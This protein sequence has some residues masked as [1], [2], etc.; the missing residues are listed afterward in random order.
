MTFN[1]VQ[2]AEQSRLRAERLL[3]SAQDSYRTRLDQ[4]KLLIGM[5]VDEPLEV[6]PVDVQVTLPRVAV[7]E[8]TE[9]ASRFR[10]DLQ[11]A[12]DRVEDAQRFVQVA[13]NGLLPDLNFT[14]EARWRNLDSTPARDI[15]GRATT[16]SAGIELDLPIDR[17]D[18]RNVYRRALINLQRSQRNF[19][20]LRERV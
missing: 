18:E 14:A 15:E 11:T 9:I 6:V 17:L 5:P 16:Y 13:E 10:L 20:E 7:E 3:V 2:R 1:Q 12:R 4:F 8:V 19:E